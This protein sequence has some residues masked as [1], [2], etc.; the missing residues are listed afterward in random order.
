MKINNTGSV[1]TSAPRRKDS[2]GST[3]GGDFASHIG[4]PRGKTAAAV[5][6]ATHIGSVAA[7]I[8]LQS[9]GDVGEGGRQAEID[10][11]ED[12]LDRLDQIRI[13]ILTG[14]LSPATLK[15]LV[16][17]LEARRSEGVDPRLAGIIDEIELRAKVELAKLSAI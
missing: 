14:G 15:S 8:A 7:L 13:G 16:A 9:G 2:A 6:G 1:R 4:A 12:L 3:A 11:A 17:R 10:R 5:S